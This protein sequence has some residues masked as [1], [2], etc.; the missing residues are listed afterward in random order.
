M[1]DERDF[2]I[3]NQKSRP[4]GGTY[5]L[6]KNIMPSNAMRMIPRERMHAA[7]EGRALDH[8]P[9]N[10]P[11]TFLSNVDRWTELTGLPVWKF[12]EWTIADPAKHGEMYKTFYETLPFDAVEPWGVQTAQFIHGREYRENLEIV[13]DDGIPWFHHKKEDRYEKVPATIHEAGSGGS[14]PEKRIVFDKKDAREKIDLPT[15]EELFAQ[16]C[17]DYIAELV[18]HYGRE[19]FV[20]SGGICNAFYSN[21][22]FFG[23]TNFFMML[24]EERELVKYMSDLILERNI[25]IIRSQAMAG[26]DA[27]YIDD[28]TATCEMISPQTYEEFSLPY[29]IEEVK[30]IQRLGKKAIIIY[31]GGIADRV[32]MIKSIGA[33]LLCMEATM[34]SYRND[35]AAVAQQLDGQ[36]ALAGNLNPSL[37][38]ELSSDEE[39]QTIMEQAVALGRKY[40]KYVTSTGSPITPGTSVERIKKFIELGHTL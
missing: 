19:R 36:T 26:G 40:G 35:Y 23:M 12:Y 14:E 22:F 20:I 11:Y 8:F 37:D 17:G 5:G 27:I 2:E 32:E 24:H 33:D 10:A 6:R 38:L 1:P 25:A 13:I 7:I 3:P 21:V 30:E 16:G 39:F 29:M 4:A 18:K 15:A 28:A 9:V 34:K 31:F